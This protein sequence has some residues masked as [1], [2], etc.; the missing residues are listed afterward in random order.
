MEETMKALHDLVS[1]GKVRYVGASSMR[2]VELAMLQNVAERNGWTNSSLC[3][4]NTTSSTAKR[5][6]R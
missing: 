2:A 1:A 6:V 4:T 5:S 3:K